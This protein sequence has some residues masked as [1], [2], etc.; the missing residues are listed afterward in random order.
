M[1]EIRDRVNREIEGMTFEE[2]ERWMDEQLAEEDEPP[3]PVTLR[4]KAG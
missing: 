1:R 4:E 3:T 2:L